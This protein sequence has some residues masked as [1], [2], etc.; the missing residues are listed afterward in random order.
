MSGRSPRFINLGWKDYTVS[1]SGKFHS[2]YAYAQIGAE[3]YKTEKEIQV[4]R[5]T[6]V[7]IVV[8]GSSTYKEKCSVTLNGVTVLSGEGQYILD[9]KAPTS[10]V[11]TKGSNTYYTCSITTG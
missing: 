5:N 4:P 8:S 6:P 9:I 3:I 2:T 10:I 7:R 1:L 11:F